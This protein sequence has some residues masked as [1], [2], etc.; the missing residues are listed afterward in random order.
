MANP[1]HLKNWV[2]DIV[3]YDTKGDLLGTARESIVNPALRKRKELI[4]MKLRGIR[5]RHTKE[6]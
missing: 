6:F 2:L 4:R 5:T 3:E 1:N